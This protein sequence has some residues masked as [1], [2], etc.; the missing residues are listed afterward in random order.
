MKVIFFVFFIALIGKVFS[1][2]G[3]V[4]NWFNSG[5]LD[6]RTESG[7][8][9][10]Y[11]YFAIFFYPAVILFFSSS[12]KNKMQ[13]S[14]KLISFVYIMSFSFLFVDMAFVGTRNVPFFML[15]VYFIFRDSKYK[16]KFNTIL[17]SIVIIT[18]IL[19]MFDYSTSQRLIGD[20]SWRIHLENTISTQVL[21]I[22]PSVLDFV[23]T[24]CSFIYP[25]VFLL[26][27]L[28][29]SIAELAYLYNHVSGF[30]LNKPIYLISE[31]CTVGLCNK[32]YYEDLILSS[33]IRAGVYQTLYASLFFDFGVYKGLLVI[34]A[35]SFVN[36]ISIIMFKRLS[37]V[38][39]IFL[40]IIVLSPIENYLYGGLGLIQIM[41]VYILYLASCF[42]MKNEK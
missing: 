6:A 25:L 13:Y 5:L 35:L 32:Q 16:I 38:N 18:F 34:I 37:V 28:S 41:M 15:L 1:R 39:F 14:S 30:E 21:S 19:V 27:Y 23:D 3:Y 17:Y 36:I 12:R 42:K 11:S 20:F 24:Y 8:G 33:N 26:H 7:G 22:K 4:I 2:Y 9:G 29:H 40:L 31:F 10:L